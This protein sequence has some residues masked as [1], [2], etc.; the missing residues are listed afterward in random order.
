MYSGKEGSK[1]YGNP[2]DFRVCA[3]Y[4]EDKPKWH[5][6]A[7]ANHSE[8]DTHQRP[9]GQKKAKSLLKDKNIVKE[10]IKELTL[11]SSDSP[12]EVTTNFGNSFD[13]ASSARQYFYSSMGDAFKAYSD[14]MKEQQE[15][16]ALQSLPTPERDEI[17]KSKA[18]LM[19]EEI[20]LK[21]A[22]VAAKKRKLAATETYKEGTYRR[23]K[24]DTN[25]LYDDDDDSE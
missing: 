6:F 22:E 18:E 15:I 8:S 17:K 10:T 4:L 21:R 2:D 1:T 13:V 24:Q 19:R 3:D 20:E 23:N 5:A 12:S 16:R 11:S 9:V 14:N 7:E 25:L